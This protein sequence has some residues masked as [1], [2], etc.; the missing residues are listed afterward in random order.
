MIKPVVAIGLLG[1]TLDRGHGPERWSGWRP[2]V[3]LCRHDDL[4]VQRFELLHGSREAAL[5]ETVAAD[6]LAQSPSTEVRRHVLDFTDPWD[7]GIVYAAL[8]EFA[9]AYPFDPDR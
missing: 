4:L 6:I 3:D 2:T 9:R 5:A 1:S 8:H 7:F